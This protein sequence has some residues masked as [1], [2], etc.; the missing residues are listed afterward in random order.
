[1]SIKN[2]SNKILEKQQEI[3]KLMQELNDLKSL[4]DEKKLAT[5]M[6]QKFCHSNHSDGCS[7][8]YDENDWRKEDSHKIYLE[9][10]RKLLEVLNYNIE[11]ALEV[12]KV[13]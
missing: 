5:A 3:T 4:P 6:H 8:F 2:L 7:W 13:L 9:K 10:A 11:I 1:M 12:V